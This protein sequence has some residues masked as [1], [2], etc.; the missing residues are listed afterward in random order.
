M[1]IYRTNALH[2]MNKYLL[3]IIVS[4]LFFSCTGKRTGYYYGKEVCHGEVQ[5]IKSVSYTASM[6]DGV[7]H[8]DS[9]TQRI[10]DYYDKEGNCTEIDIYRPS[11]GLR[12]KNLFSYDDKGVMT[13]LKA[14]TGK[15]KLKYK[16]IPTFDEH[17]NEIEEKDYYSDG[18]LAGRITFSYPEKSK[19]VDMNFYD[20]KG[21]LNVKRT[22]LFDEKQNAIEL[23]ETEGGTSNKY[24]CKYDSL[25]EKGNWRKRTTFLNDQVSDVTEREIQYFQ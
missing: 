18:A 24:T 14:V 7:I 6:K 4:T 15:G 2:G 23:N 17:K 20:E 16:R 13:E 12:E 21:S 1:Y 22:I 11:G 9:A 10:V 5:M 19:Q 8:K 3:F 25:D